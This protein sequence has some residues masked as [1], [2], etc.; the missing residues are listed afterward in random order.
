MWGVF[1]LFFKYISIPLVL[2]EAV[3]SVCPER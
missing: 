3:D 2:A 1:C